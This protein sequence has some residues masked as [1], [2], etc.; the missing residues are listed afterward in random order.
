MADTPNGE[1]VV[2]ETPKNDAITP[3]T[4]P[5][6]EKKTEDSQVEELRKKAEQAE[7]RANQLANQL[8]AKED[9][10]AAAAAKKL[11][12]KEEYKTL[13]EQE[14]AKNEEIL[15]EREADELKKQLS[16]SQASILNDYSDDVKALAEDAGLSLT[17]VTD[18]AV[19]SFK[20][21]LDKFQARLGNQVVRPNNPGAPS[22]QKEYTKE[23][24]REILADP[25]KRDAYYRAKDGVTAMMM[26]PAK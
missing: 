6:E 11:E 4:P 21:R 24:L 14:K 26:A 23:E 19:A 9:A 1:T 18:E 7:M 15:R 17:D 8:K 25:V 10:E 3:P 22:G 20:G 16:E 13:F 12:E 5:L 2:S